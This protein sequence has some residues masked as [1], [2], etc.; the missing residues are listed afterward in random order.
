MGIKKI[1]IK[2]RSYYYFDYIIEIQDFKAKP[3]KVHKKS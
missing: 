2:N 3:L 1:N